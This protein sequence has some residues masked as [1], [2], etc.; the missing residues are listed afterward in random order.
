MTRPTIGF[1]RYLY[2]AVGREW[3]WFER[4]LLS[5]EAWRR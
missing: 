4:C 1:F 2:D 3:T 5:D